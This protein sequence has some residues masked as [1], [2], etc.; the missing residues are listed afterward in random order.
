[1]TI[2]S[3]RLQNFRSY[4]DDTFEFGSGVNIIVGPN[5]S[6]KTNLLESILLVCRGGSYRVSTPGLI[7]FDSDWSRIEA[8]SSNGSRI[9]KIDARV[10]PLKKTYTVNDDD[11]ARLPT[12]K[13]IPVVLFEPDHLRL[14]AGSPERRRAHLDDLLEQTTPGYGKTRRAYQRVLMQRNALLKKGYTAGAGQMFAWNIRLSELGGQIAIARHSL[15]SI[16]DERLADIYPAISHDKTKVSLEYL[17]GHNLSSYSTS[18]LKQLENTTDQDFQR[19]FTGSGPH[20]DD[21]SIEFDG[22]DVRDVASRGEVRTLLLGLKIVELELLRDIRGQSP[23]L[24]LDDVFSELD[25]ARRQ[26]LTNFLQSY[27]TFITTTDADVVVQHFMDK[28]TIIPI[29]K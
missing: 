28:C 24:L 22:R 8:G 6:G 15:T 19:G 3:I 14:L 16:L 26:A 29:Q 9:V 23:L 4:L 7:N 20:R 1:M 12:S 5:A 11:Y 17:T 21:L 13:T 2:H 25:G 18:L 27:Q 10:S